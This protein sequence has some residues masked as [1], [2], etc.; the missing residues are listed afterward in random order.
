MWPMDELP[1]NIRSYF[2]FLYIAILHPVYYSIS[3]SKYQSLKNAFIFFLTNISLSLMINITLKVLIAK[4]PSLIFPIISETLFWIPV[5]CFLMVFLG[6]ILH[7][8]A[9]ISGGKGKISDSIKAA[10]YSSITL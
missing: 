8:L 7:L 3:V 2:K 4:N 5:S 9:K 6:L 1:I 10:C